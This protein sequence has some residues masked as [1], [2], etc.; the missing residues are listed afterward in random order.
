[1]CTAACPSQVLFLESPARCFELARKERL[2]FLAQPETA[3][4]GYGGLSSHLVLLKP[5]TTVAAILA[6]NAA[7][8]HFVSYTRRAYTVPLLDSPHRI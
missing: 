8:G 6:A 1:M 5:D 4:R 3:G 2:V 7:A